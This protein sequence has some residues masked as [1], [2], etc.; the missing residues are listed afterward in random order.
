MYMFIYYNLD[1][2]WIYIYIH[3]RQKI[4]KNFYFGDFLQ[5]CEVYRVF[6]YLKYIPLSRYYFGVSLLA[7]N[8]K[9]KRKGSKTIISVFS[10]LDYG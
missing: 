1:L 3:Y 7:L 10:Q 8:I 4:W 2:S 6:I 5:F 9:L